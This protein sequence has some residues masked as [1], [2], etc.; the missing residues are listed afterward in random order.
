MYLSDLK[1]PYFLCLSSVS[2]KVISMGTTGPLPM[3]AAHQRPVSPTNC[4]DNEPIPKPFQWI[5]GTPRVAQGQEHL[6]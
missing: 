2:I 1:I 6:L 3:V 4:R 5:T